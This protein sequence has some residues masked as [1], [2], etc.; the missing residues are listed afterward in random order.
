ML[1]WLRSILMTRRSSPCPVPSMPPA[2]NERSAARRFVD[3]IERAMQLGLWE[4]ADRVARSGARLAG[5]YPMVAEAIARLRLAQHLPEESWRVIEG[6]QASSSALRLLRAVC[7][8]RLGKQE[9][10]ISDLTRWSRRNT[11][12]LAARTLLALLELDR[13]E[14]PAAGQALERNL[15]QLSDPTSAAIAHL[16][17][18]ERRQRQRSIDAAQRVALIPDWHR[19]GFD[20]EL[21]LASTGGSEHVRREVLGEHHARALAMEL[22]P[23][24]HLLPALVEAQVRR[25]H[26]P[27]AELLARAIELALPELT[28]QA[29]G[30]E[31]LARLHLALDHRAAARQWAQA[32]LNINAMSAT[33]AMLLQETAPDLETQETIDDISMTINERGRAA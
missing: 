4:H 16:A 3:A 5:R 29:T 6:C 8:V 22:I 17:H 14:W 24:E 11:A 27:T 28:E 10:A 15:R 21:L 23:A 25:L 31:A 9:E 32:G 1:R 19:A 26:R 33:L 13:G 2:A 30:H 7:L 20:I 18:L 12:P